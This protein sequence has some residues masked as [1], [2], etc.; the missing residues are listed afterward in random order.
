LRARIEERVVLES[1]EWAWE[2]RTYMPDVALIEWPHGR[3]GGG[4]VA[5]EEEVAEPVKVSIHPEPLVEGY[6]EI[7]DLSS[8]G[9]LVTTIEF[10]SPTNKTA[11]KGADGFRKKERDCLRAQ[12][13]VVEIDLI[14]GGE[15]ILSVPVEKLPE[16]QRDPPCACVVEAWKP[17]E[18][19][20]YPFNIQKCLPAIRIPLRQSDKQARL[21]IQAVFDQ[22]YLNGEYGADID[23]SHDPK[24]PIS[25]GE[26]E[27]LQAHLRAQGLRK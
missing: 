12:V 20:F 25:L 1:E 5:V 7:R 19:L 15:H 26:S 9:R 27:W 11:G 6:I 3:E 23:Y 16:G 18:F 24:V 2:S 22:A 21:D 13:S 14:R 8:G 4:A 10:A 17:N